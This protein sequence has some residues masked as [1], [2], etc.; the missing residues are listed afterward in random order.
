[1]VKY[2]NLYQEA[3]VE[4]D[5]LFKRINIFK[6]VNLLTIWNKILTAIDRDNVL[7]QK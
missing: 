6:F 7:L 4:L 5:G 2:D 1:M 3:N